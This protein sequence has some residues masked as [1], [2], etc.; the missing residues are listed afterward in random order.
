MR[1]TLLLS[2][3]LGML[4]ALP[5]QAQAARIAVIDLQAVLQES[6]PG[7]TAMEKLKS[8]QQDVRSDLQEQKQSLDQ[9]KKELQQQS[10]MLSEEAKQDKK[11]QFQ[12]QAQRFQSEYQQYQQRMQK[13]EE[14]LREPI[15]DVLMNVIQ[16][17]GE[18]NDLELILDK[19]NSG[20]MYNEQSLEVTDA[21]IDK[22]NQAW[23][24]SDREI[25]SE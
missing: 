16:D 23:E 8:Y 6:N 1:K 18:N 20:V 10:M 2:C 17:Y 5:F 25:P 24:E 9:L 11:T 13:K 22:L 14:E 15:I 7:K 4:L 12:K 21:I 3:L 19:R